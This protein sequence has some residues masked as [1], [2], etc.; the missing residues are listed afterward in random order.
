MSA[1][2]YKAMKARIEKPQ[3]ESQTLLIN[4]DARI[5]ALHEIGVPTSELTDALDELWEHLIANRFALA[6]DDSELRA[7]QEGAA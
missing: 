2:L 6:L 3:K 1:E 7:Y 4:L 5:T